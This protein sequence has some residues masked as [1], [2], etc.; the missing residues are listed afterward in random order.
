MRLPSS[1]DF[2]RH[3]ARRHHRRNVFHPWV[4]NRCAADWN[5][6]GNSFALARLALVSLTFGAAA[7][8]ARGGAGAPI[9]ITHASVI[10]V[11]SG[12][13]EKDFTVIISGKRITYVGPSSSAP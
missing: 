8:T 10:D 3:T 11:R 7:C 5:L 12:A 13:V 9:A 2:Y 6:A 1:H 4:A